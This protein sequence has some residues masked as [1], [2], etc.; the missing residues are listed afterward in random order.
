MLA[1]QGDTVAAG[2]LIL[3]LDDSLLQA[4]RQSAAAA[5]EAA[6][7]NLTVSQTGAELAQAALR[8]GQASQEAVQANTQ[9]ELVVAQRA[10]DDLYSNNDVARTVGTAEC[11]RGSPSCARGTV[12][13]G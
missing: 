4:Q 6:N 8:A 5:L 10:L 7:K 11:R 1:E 9:A 3:R 12:P 13:L 2:N